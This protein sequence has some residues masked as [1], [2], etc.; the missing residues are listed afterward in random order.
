MLWGASA[1][2][3]HAAP[4][5]H[6]LCMY[7]AAEWSATDPVG[8]WDPVLQAAHL[9]W[10]GGR[11]LG[12][13]SLLALLDLLCQLQTSAD[14]VAE[15]MLAQAPQEVQLVNWRAHTRTHTPHHKQALC[16]MLL[17]HVTSLALKGAAPRPP[18]KPATM[19]WT[20][21]TS[22]PRVASNPN[23]AAC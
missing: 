22:L 13:L 6:V 17:A 12:H 5:H 10:G 4:S 19:T 2:C 21:A 16:C 14:E 15:S 11:E 1:L 23:A 9:R 8:S 18:Q 3:T 20:G 7:S